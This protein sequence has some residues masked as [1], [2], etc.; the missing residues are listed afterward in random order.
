MQRGILFALGVLLGAALA[1]A[2]EAVPLSAPASA[3]AESQT[4]YYAGPGVTAPEPIPI[5]PSEVATGHC[6]HLDG[7]AVLSVLV[8]ATGVPRRVYLLDPAGNDLDKF[9]VMLA[10]RERFRP[11]TYNGAPASVQIA[12]SID[13]KAC[14]EQK[15]NDAGQKIGVVQLRSAPEQTVEIEQDSSQGAT[16]TAGSLPSQADLPDPP[17]VKVTRDISRPQP[18]NR[19]EAEYSDKARREKLSG[20]VLISLIVDTHGMPQNLRLVRSLEPSLDQNALYAVDRYRFK[21]AM[22][23]D[24]TPVPVMITV[25]VDFRVY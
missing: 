22:K 6:K 5:A 7:K 16:Y 3:Q 2:Q 14:I 19:I 24:G 23:K 25:E 12:L 21:P 9:A 13:M 18:L 10:A 17:P 1:F 20:A 4:V 8:D 11:G 15:K